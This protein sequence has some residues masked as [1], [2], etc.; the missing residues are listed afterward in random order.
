[1]GNS[2]QPA[3]STATTSGKTTATF[4]MLNPHARVIADARTPRERGRFRSVVKGL[5]PQHVALR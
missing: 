2:E 1:V 3:S 5:P 4:V